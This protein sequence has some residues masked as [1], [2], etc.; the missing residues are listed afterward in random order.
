MIVPVAKVL[1]RRCNKATF[2]TLQGN[3]RGQYDI[4]LNRVDGLAA[5][6]DGLP[7]TDPTELGGFSVQVPI[8]RFGG[9]P[10]AEETTIGLRYMGDGSE[11]RDWYIRSQ[12]PGTAYELWRP[13]NGVPDAFEDGANE[14][15]V[16]ARDVH[17]RFHARW[18]HSADLAAVPLVLRSAMVEAEVG[19]REFS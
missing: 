8:E 6:L 1:W 18:I 7:R 2:D 5:F 15:L 17:D 9:E 11:R 4:R 13:G 14:F 19:V 10:S 16:I 3:S 12:R